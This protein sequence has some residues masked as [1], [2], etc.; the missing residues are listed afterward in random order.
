MVMSPLRLARERASW[1]LE[2]WCGGVGE[3]LWGDFWM[4]LCGLSCW[5]GDGDSGVRGQWDSSVM[6]G[7]CVLLGQL[8]RDKRGSCC[9]VP[10]IM[11]IAFLRNI[12]E[13]VWSVH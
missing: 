13:T 10:G 8:R 7:R 11:K 1:M 12:S 2:G 3:I 5:V 6:V 9:F 4:S